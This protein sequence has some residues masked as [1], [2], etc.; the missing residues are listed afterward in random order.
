[1]PEH[2]FPGVFVEEAASSTRVIAGVPTSTTAFVASTVTV[3]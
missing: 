2:L 1:M 3:S